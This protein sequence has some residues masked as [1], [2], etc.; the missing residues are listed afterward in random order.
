MKRRRKRVWIWT[1]IERMRCIGLWK[2]STLCCCCWVGG[3]EK[4]E[5]LCD[6]LLCRKMMTVGLM[7]NA[8][9]LM[10]DAMSIL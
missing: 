5:M 7:E 1:G 9:V 4:R 2:L 10:E 3:G 8:D 6:S